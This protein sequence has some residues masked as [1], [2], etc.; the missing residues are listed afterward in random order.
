MKSLSRNT[1]IAAALSVVV[2]AST[3]AQ[4]HDGRYRGRDGIDAGDIIAGA[5]VLGGI[6]AIASAGSRQGS[7][8]DRYDNGEYGNRRYDD[9]DYGYYQNGYGSRSAVD[10]CVRAAER[11]ASR[12]GRARIT[13]VTSIYRIRGGYEVHGRLVVADRYFRGGGYDGWDRYGYRYDS[14][15]SDYDKGKFS[16][17]ARFG[18][19]QGL[20]I[21]GLRG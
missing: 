20:R 10:Q 16:C 14:Y 4:A 19:I 21:S 17:K 2:S 9:N 11:R 15:G 6:A 12:F 5:L 7:G 13:D 18:E 3:S 8:R 1:L